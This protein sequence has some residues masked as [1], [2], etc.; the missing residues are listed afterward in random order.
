VPQ[1]VSFGPGDVIY[2]TTEKLPD[3]ILVVDK[4]FQFVPGGGFQL[5][6]AVEVLENELFASPSLQTMFH[7]IH[8]L[9]CTHAMRAA[10]KLT[11]D[12]HP[13]I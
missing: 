12:R 1:Q 7:T 8:G 2:A 13:P 3:R 9:G 5:D 11:H 10:V 6:R 4:I